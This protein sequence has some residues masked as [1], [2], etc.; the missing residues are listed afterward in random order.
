MTERSYMIVETPREPQ[1][2][3]FVERNVG[4]SHRGDEFVIAGPATTHRLQSL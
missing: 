3:R 1:R 2:A 4:G